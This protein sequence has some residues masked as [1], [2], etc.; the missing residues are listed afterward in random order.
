MPEER[1]LIITDTVGFIRSLP[2]ELIEAFRATLEELGE[3]DI[4]LHVA[5]ASHPE[6]E[7]QCTAVEA[8]LESL[9]FHDTPRLLILNKADR[10]NDE[11]RESLSHIYRDA[12]F[13]SAAT[14]EGL[15]ALS[16]AVVSRIDWSRSLS[17]S[18]SPQEQLHALMGQ[19]RH[20]QIY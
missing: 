17:V 8:I 6:L 11:T 13:V 2:K 20:M 1:E 12:L 16:A 19:R 4:L 5:D 10:L 18:S 15:N 14:G 7:M 9:S 3:A